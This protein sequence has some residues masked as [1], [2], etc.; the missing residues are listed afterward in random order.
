LIHIYAKIIFLS[1]SSEIIEESLVLIL[2]GRSSLDEESMAAFFNGKI[3]KN[4]G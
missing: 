4:K 3:V 2:G 1:I